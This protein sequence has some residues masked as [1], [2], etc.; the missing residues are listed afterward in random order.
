MNAGEFARRRARIEGEHG[1]RRGYASRALKALIREAGAA[2][3]IRNGKVVGWR[4]PNGQEVCKKRRYRTE[5]EAMLELANVRR[6]PKTP[7][8]PCR[9]YLC[10]H[11]S[12]WH[13]TSQRPYAE[14]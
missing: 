3:I 5:P 13:L 7:H 8:I 2:I 12:G 4:M 6:D 10:P 11:C 9:V 1:R 14:Q